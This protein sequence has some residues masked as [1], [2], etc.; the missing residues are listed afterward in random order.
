MSAYVRRW[1]RIDAYRCS[2][3]RY[4]ALVRF[5]YAAPGPLPSPRP[6]QILCEIT[7]R[8]HARSGLGP[9]RQK[10]IPTGP[11]AVSRRRYRSDSVVSRP[12]AFDVKYERPSSYRIPGRSR[13]APSRIRTSYE[14]RFRPIPLPRTAPV[15]QGAPAPL[16]DRVRRKKI[17]RRYTSVRCVGADSFVCLR[18]SGGCEI[19]A[20]RRPRPGDWPPMAGAWPSRA[21]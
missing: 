2:V 21:L 8:F 17:V 15:K 19:G 4:R 16:R 11:R 9:R 20:D 1:R 5:R 13:Q 14:L 6:S 12:D 3:S 18:G 7:R 10:W